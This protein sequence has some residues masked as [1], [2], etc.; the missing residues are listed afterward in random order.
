MVG[1]I[2]V[3]SNQYPRAL[4]LGRQF[5]ALG[6]P[7]VMG[8]FHVSGCISMLPTLAGR[9]AGS[10]RSRHPSVRRR[11]RR[12]HGRGFARC[13]GGQSQ[14][15]LQIS[16]RP[17]GNGGRRLS[18]PAA[19]GGDA[20][21]RSLFE[22]RCRPRLS[23]PVQLLHHHQRAGPQIALSHA[24]RRR[25]DRARQRGAGHHAVLHHR[26]QFRPQPQLGAD[27]RPA[28]RTAR[29]RQIQH[30][31]V[32]A[33]RHAVPPH[34]GLHREIGA[35]RLH[36]HLHRAGEHQSRIAD[37]REEAPEQDLGISRDA[38]GVAGAKGHDLCRL[39]SR[40]PDRHAG[41]DRARHRD[42]QEGT[43]GRHSRILLSDAAA[44]LRRSQESASCAGCRWTPT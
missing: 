10:A 39:H 1:L 32:A 5:R 3:Q 34:S 31:A 4:D 16:Q 18:D 27:P 43:A 44:G 23:V 35:R 40:L 22:L 15:D 29:A 25:G 7:V 36:R 6:L 11:G 17:A 14:A 24:R 26:R 9:S 12:P 30:P 42:H 33:G 41:I 19:R 21:R 38:A 13:R 8:G 20:G 37:G 2:G 28:D